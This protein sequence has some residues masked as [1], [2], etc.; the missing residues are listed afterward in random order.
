V[1][2]PPQAFDRQALM[3][4]PRRLLS[5]GSP[6]KPAVWKVELPEGGAAAWKEVP[7]GGGPGR[8]LAR[9]LLRRE[10]RI[11]ERLSGVPGVPQILG[12][13]D[14]GSFLCTWLEG[15]PL[16][17]AAFE[18]SPRVLAES[19]RALVGALHARGVVHLDLRQRQ[20]VLVTATGGLAC[21][22]FGAALAP[23]R[24]LRP[25]CFPLLAWVDRQAALKYLARWAP[26]ELSAAE[27]RSHL[28][29]LRW[30][31]W[32]FVSPHHPRGEREALRKRL[33]ELAERAR[34]G[35]GGRKRW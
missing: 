20:N 11:L 26:Q 30:R 6:F 16:D 13:P 7:P 2:P 25:L 31:R 32:W 27:A 29:A 12:R 35:V 21:V 19:L 3:G 18:R 10:S 33:R 23:P 4:L 14:R 15:E 34:E 17:R 22:D 8:L 9:F 1:N 24:W 5:R 28:R